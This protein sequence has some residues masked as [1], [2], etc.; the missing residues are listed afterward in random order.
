MT[1]PRTLPALGALL[2]LALVAP[3]ASAFEFGTPGSKAPYRSPQNF[4]LE[5]RG[6]PYSPDV[7]EEPGLAGRPFETAFGDNPRVAIGIEFDWQVLRIPYLGT[8]GPGL[9]LGYVSMSR[10][11]S[12]LS[13]RQSGDKYSLT[14]YPL[15]LDAVLRMDVFWREIGIP[16][17][18]YA[19]AGLG[20]GIWRASNSGGTSDFNGVSGRGATLGPH[21]AAGAMFALD[22]IDHGATRNMDNAVGINGTYLFGEVYWGNL[23]GL[24]QDSVLY[25]GTKSWAAGLAFEF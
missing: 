16:L 23:N 8:L 25:V 13:G 3:T 2:G 1:M 7:D 6:G 9:G 22:A 24:F 17:I 10:D 19:K 12:T 15:Y 18:P 20:Y 11:A 21:L 4:A 5:F 14:I